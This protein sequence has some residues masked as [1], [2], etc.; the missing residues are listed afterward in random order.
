MVHSLIQSTINFVSARF[1][2][3]SL[4]TLV[5]MVMAGRELLALLQAERT[6]SAG[7]SAIDGPSDAAY[8][9]RPFGRR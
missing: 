8:I 4:S 6:E 9:A 7:I 1:F 3:F 5:L 2:I